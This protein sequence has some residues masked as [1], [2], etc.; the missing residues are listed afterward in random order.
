M[1]A[2][3]LQ[4]KEVYSGLDLPYKLTLKHPVPVDPQGLYWFGVRSTAGQTPEDGYLVYGP[5]P[6]GGEDYPQN[7]GLSFQILM[8]NGE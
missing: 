4:E 8:A 7:F 6:L 3:R 5:N 2:H 1:E